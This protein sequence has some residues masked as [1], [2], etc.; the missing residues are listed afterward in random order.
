MCAINNEI[1][2]YSV[3]V[4]FC[5]N[6]KSML[7]L[8]LFSFS[9]CLSIS[10]T[11]SGVFCMP[12]FI[13][14]WNYMRDI[15]VGAANTQR[16]HFYGFFSSFLELAGPFYF[17]TAK[18]EDKCL[19]PVRYFPFSFSCSFS[20][21]FLVCRWLQFPWVSVMRTIAVVAYSVDDVRGDDMKKNNNEMKTCKNTCIENTIWW[22]VAVAECVTSLKCLK[23]CRRFVN[24]AQQWGRLV[25]GSLNTWLDIFDT[26]HISRRST[27]TGKQRAYFH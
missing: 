11:I 17:R 19:F 7:N 9:L 14:S 22:L 15:W 23:P 24:R 1:K 21:A 16:Q 4:Y 20:F 6:A 10:I 27:T 3:N 18:R 26:D 5:S 2:V 25:C 13:S 8:P 12:W